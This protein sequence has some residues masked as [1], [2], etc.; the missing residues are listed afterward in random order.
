MAAVALGASCEEVVPTAPADPA[1]AASAVVVHR[2]DVDPL[3]ECRGPVDL[4]GYLAAARRAGAASAAL[5]QQIT[6]LKRSGPEQ[7]AAS[8]FADRTENCGLD[9]NR[10]P[11]GRAVF[12][13]ALRFPNQAAA[14]RVWAQGLFSVPNPAEGEEAPGLRTGVA[15]GL[16]S[17]SWIQEVDAGGQ[18]VTYAFWQQGRFVLVVIAA[19]L[20]PEAVRTLTARVDRRAV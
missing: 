6:E 13:F 3:V 17:H 10:R 11:A 1:P 18:Q 14:S 7:A 4:D 12:G 20:D 8:A 5:E 15:T 9:P 16:S 19:G 2:Q